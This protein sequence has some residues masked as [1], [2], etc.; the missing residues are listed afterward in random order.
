LPIALA[1]AAHRA[2]DG[3]GTMV[4]FWKYYNC[5]KSMI[6]QI[7]YL[8]S[9]LSHPAFERNHGQA[10]LAEWLQAVW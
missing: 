2:E 9:S 4:N 8:E 7:I 10:W 3:E 1:R 5:L 6:R